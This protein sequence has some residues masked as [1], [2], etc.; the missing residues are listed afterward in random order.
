MT[1]LS[2]LLQIPEMETFKTF[3]GLLIPEDVDSA[4]SLEDGVAK[5]I[6]ASFDMEAIEEI[7]IVLD[8]LLQSSFS[9]EE[10]ERVWRVGG[11]IY[12]FHGESAYRRFFATCRN[13]VER[14]LAR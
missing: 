13:Q 8:F 1:Q 14:R 4:D 7:K 11:P 10:L 5:V 9:E 6:D 2:D 12:S 3:A